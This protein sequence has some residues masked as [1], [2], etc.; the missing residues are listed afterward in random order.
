MVGEEEHV[1]R[2]HAFE[3][4]LCLDESAPGRISAMLLIELYFRSEIMENLNPSKVKAEIDALEGNR[5]SC[6][7]PETPFKGKALSGLWH[8][9][10]QEDGISSLA[11]NL[12]IESKRYTYELSDTALSELEEIDDEDE[13]NWILAGS[14]AHEFTHGN[15]HRRRERAA[16][17]GEW[18]IFAR[19]EGENYYLCLGSH[20]EG[21]WSIRDKIL[22]RPCY[23]F[24]FL[25]DL[26]L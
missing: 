15:L 8:K 5:V 24:P 20:Q 13:R 21:D 25:T 7:K 2:V 6:T 14:F 12:L 16:M 26:L 23:E 10:Y 17:T 9:H 19:H 3:R 1:E 22:A 18:V 11:T 4:D